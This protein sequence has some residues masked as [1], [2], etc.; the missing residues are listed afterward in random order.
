MALV[1]MS[2]ERFSL[3]PGTQV[4]EEDFGLLFYT[5]EGPR[6]YF[7]SCGPLLDAS[8]F[9]GELT[10][11]QWIRLKGEEHAFEGR[12]EKIRQVLE[13]LRNKGVIAEC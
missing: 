11:D 10:L 12:I 6:L 5:M 3:A 9:G 8:F 2:R 4:R 7:L 1:E 13:Q